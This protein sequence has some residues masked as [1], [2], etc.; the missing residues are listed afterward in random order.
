MVSIRDIA[1]KAKVSVATVSR[2][3]DPQKRGLVREETRK[4][5][6]KIIQKYH[7]V[8]NQA[9]KALRRQQSDTIGMVTPFSTDVVKSPYFE[10]LIA[11]IIEGI[12]PLSYDLK[13]I[14][15]R[16][17]ELKT[18]NLQELLQKHAVDGIVFLTWRLLPNLVREIEHHAKIPAVLINDVSPK[19]RCSIVYCENK[20]GVEKICSH[21]LSRGFKK[22]GMLRG[23]EHISHDARERFLAFKACA[24]KFGFPLKESFLALAPRFDE[25][26]GY[27]TL[28][29]WIEKG[30]L[31]RAI[32]CA[33]DDLAAG[34]IRALRDKKVKVP[35]EV[36]IVG[37]DD[38]ERNAVLN[39]PLTSVRQPLEMMGRAAIE[40]LSKLIS[41]EAK[42][43]VQLKFE[44][45]LVVRASA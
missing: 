22:I 25:E 39:P 3:L 9:A 33:N 40:I 28:S 6:E 13:W 16:D 14:M 2:L 12:R 24:K 34:A 37:Y 10:G 5:I 4:R 23:P 44:P 7:Y 19:V 36:A 35:E 21:L 11:G 26:A 17:E 18:S 20:I 27:Q 31:P 43:S 45:E 8:P 32:F 15:I 38:S 42:G 29:T 1:N 41:K 30:K